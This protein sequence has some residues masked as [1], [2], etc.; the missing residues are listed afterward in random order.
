MPRNRLQYTVCVYIEKKSSILLL[1]T[2]EALVTI[3]ALPQVG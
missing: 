2:L 1:Y 3:Q